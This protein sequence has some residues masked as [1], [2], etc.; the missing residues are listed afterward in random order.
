[1]KKFQAL[2]FSLSCTVTLFAAQDAA[3]IFRN[4]TRHVDFNG[5]NL[6]YFNS[7]ELGATINA[8]PAHL[9][10]MAVA[11][12]APA[13]KVNTTRCGANII[14]KTL[15]LSALK[16]IASSEKQYKKDLY[17]SK[18]V[19]YFGKDAQMPGLFNISRFANNCSLNEALAE[20]PSDV[21][22]AIK[23]P[24]YPGDLNTELEKNI[25]IMGNP[26][27]KMFYAEIR[28]Q[29]AKNGIDANKLNA[30][31]GGNWSIIVAGKSEE[32]LRFTISIPDND[33]TLTALLKKHLPPDAATPD[34]S[35]I[36]DPPPNTRPAILYMGN[37]VMLVSDAARCAKIERPFALP[38]DFVRMLPANA[39]GFKV[40]NLSPELLAG[41]KQMKFIR[42]NPVA[43]KVVNSLKPGLAF[44]TTLAESDAIRSITAADF[45][46]SELLLGIISII[47]EIKR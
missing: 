12:E 41:L 18:T 13:D 31:I 1:M 39:A 25:G 35:F 45:S 9:S 46:A 34:R 44:E 19:L 2:L 24:C 10:K 32:T 36:P 33:G 3:Q 17:L 27:I 37:R 26:E 47:N 43:L 29:L 40:V 4:T 8:L 30:S 14:L 7:I 20:F 21:I 42:K 5:E 28:S 11:F 16:A 22:A 23:F 15:N 38:A 6:F